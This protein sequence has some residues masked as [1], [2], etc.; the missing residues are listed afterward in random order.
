MKDYEVAALRGGDGFDHDVCVG[1]SH[2]VSRVQARAG[3][4][5]HHLREEGEGRGVQRSR[6]MQ[7]ACARC[8]R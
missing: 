7:F 3:R 8:A 1:L 6:R 4:D 5:G 2:I